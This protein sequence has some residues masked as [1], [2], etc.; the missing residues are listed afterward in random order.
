MS[1]GVHTQSYYTLLNNKSASDY[2]FN[3][4]LKFSMG[5]VFKYVARCG[6]KENNTAESDLNKAIVYTLSSD[7]EFSFIEKAILRLRNMLLFCE[8]ISDDIEIDNILHAVLNFESKENIVRMI[9]SYM[10]SRGI[11]VRPEY[12]HYE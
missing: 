12:K 1:D 2:I 4:K 10:K 9:I 6:R 3:G 5:N 7:K 11:N 8:E